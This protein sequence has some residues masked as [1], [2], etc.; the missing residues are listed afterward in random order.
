MP[1]LPGYGTPFEPIPHLPGDCPQPSQEEIDAVE[2]MWSSI[3]RPLTL[4]EIAKILEAHPEIIEIWAKH[5]RVVFH[6]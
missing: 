3:K 2:A 5:A 1:S 4:S 6:T